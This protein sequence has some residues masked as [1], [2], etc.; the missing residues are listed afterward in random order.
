M[1]R[2]RLLPVAA[3]VAILLAAGLAAALWLDP[4]RRLEAAVRGTPTFEGRSAAAWGDDLK[5]ADDVERSLAFEKLRAGKAGA[6]PALAWVVKSAG[7]PESR[8]HA[9]DLLGQIGA[10]ARPAAG[11]LVAALGDADPTVKAMALKSLTRLAPTATEALPPELDGVV[12][13]LLGRFPEVEAIRAVSD[14]K[15]H[16]AEAVP[17]LAG[18]LGHPD[19]AVRWNAARALGKIGA[20][21]KPAAAAI[22]AQFNDPVSLVREHAA[23]ALGDI[24]PAVAETVPDLVKA[25]QDP[26]WKVRKDAVRALGQ[27]GPAALSVLPRVQ[28]MK[29]DPEADVREK[30]ADAERKID[31][32]LAGARAK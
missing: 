13:A 11:V 9:A 16:A 12:A 18:L 7:R 15:R 30:A 29:A 26:D 2:S 10:D 25:L 20:P 17:Q 23:E 1:R 32:S 8:W 6:V 21:A 31:P 4:S 28:A 27:M 5:T 19:P 3:A 24:G 14:Y 22:V